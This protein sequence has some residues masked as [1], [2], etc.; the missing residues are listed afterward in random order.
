MPLETLITVGAYPNSSCV[1]RLVQNWDIEIF[2][3]NN[4]HIADIVNENP[5]KY[6]S[7]VFIK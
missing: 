4:E 2:T 3:L 6:L 7:V 5:V 1:D